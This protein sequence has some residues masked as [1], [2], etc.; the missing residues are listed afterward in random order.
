MKVAVGSWA[1]FNTSKRFSGVIPGKPVVETRRYH[2]SGCLPGM[3]YNHE[4]KAISP[5]LIQPQNSKAIAAH[6]T[7]DSLPKQG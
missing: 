3:V 6:Q 5:S 7:R 4:H 1:L 2:S